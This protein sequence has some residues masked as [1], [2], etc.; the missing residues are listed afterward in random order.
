[1]PDPRVPVER[2]RVQGYSKSA[3]TGKPSSY[4]VILPKAWVNYWQERLGREIDEVD[5]FQEGDELIIRPVE[6]AVA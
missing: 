3:E 6:G 4:G 1:M 2:R 5:I